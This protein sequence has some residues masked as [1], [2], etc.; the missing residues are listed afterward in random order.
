[1]W[2]QRSRMIRLDEGK[3]KS[4]TGGVVRAGLLFLPSGWPASRLPN[5]AFSRPKIKEAFL[6]SFRGASLCC[7]QN[8]RRRRRDQGLIPQWNVRSLRQDL[9]A[10]AS[11]CILSLLLQ[12]FFFGWRVG[13]RLVVAEPAA[14]LQ[15]RRTC[16]ATSKN[17]VFGGRTQSVWPTLWT[18]I[19]LEW[20]TWPCNHYSQQ[21]GKD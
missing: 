1:M 4:A 10:K 14:L 2:C 15:R 13:K 5:E 6:P 9:L 18:K 17:C 20:R 7:W 21:P 16:R 8:G 12:T 11:S 19:A 3:D